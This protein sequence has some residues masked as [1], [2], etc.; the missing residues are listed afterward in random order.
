MGAWV[1]ILP[2]MVPLHILG[3]WLCLCHFRSLPTLFCS[4]YLLKFLLANQVLIQVL[5]QLNFH[6]IPKLNFVFS[7]TAFL[8][9]KNMYFKDST[10]LILNYTKEVVAGIAESM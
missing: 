1:V 3:S 6:R 8:W 9:L 7:F 10:Q 2:P 5:V 4:L